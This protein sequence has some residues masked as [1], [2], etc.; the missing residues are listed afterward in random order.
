MAGTTDGV[1]RK[2]I[3]RAVLKEQKYLAGEALKRALMNLNPDAGRFGAET[4][5]FLAILDPGSEP[6]LSPAFLLEPTDAQH[7]EKHAR[8]KMGRMELLGAILKEDWLLVTGN[9]DAAAAQGTGKI[10]GPVLI[11]DDE[12]EGDAPS[13]GGS[14]EVDGGS[15]EVDADNG[16]PASRVA[17]HS[18]RNN[19]NGS[20]RGRRAPEPLGQ[21]VLRWTSS[22]MPVTGVVLTPEYTRKSLVLDL[23]AGATVGVMSVPQG[24][25]YA[26]LAGLPPERGMYAS[27]V[28]VIAYALCGGSR[29][30]SL[31][32]A[33]IDSLIVFGSLQGLGLLEK[34]A[35]A[36]AAASLMAFMVGVIQVLMGFLHVGSFV[37][38]LAKPVVAGFT[39]GS[40]VTIA[41]SQVKS[42][43]GL[44]SPKTY[45]YLIEQVYHTLPA[46]GETNG[47]ALGIGLS[48]IA[49]LVALKFIKGKPFLKR[50]APY[51]PDP[52][53]LVVFATLASYIVATRRP[54]RSPAAPV[55]GHIPS[56]FPAPSVGY[57]G[58]ASSGLKLIPDAFLL[59][60]IG[61]LETISIGVA[62]AEPKGHALAANR[63]FLVLG[64]CNLTSAI[65]GGFPVAALFSRSAVAATAGSVSQVAGLTSGVV[66]IL[67]SYAITPLLFYLPRSALAAIVIVAV[68]GLLRFDEAVR[69]FRARKTDF[70]MWAVAFAATA[71]A[72]VAYGIASSVAFSVFLV[73]L[74]A[75]RPRVTVLG[76][77]A[78]TNSYACVSLGLAKASPHFGVVP[79]RFEAPLVFFNAAY[80][81]ST[82]VDI[83][84]YF[85]A[86]HAIVI[87]FLAMPD[88][89]TTGV[90]AFEWVAADLTRR[91]IILAIAGPSPG[92]LGFLISSGVIQRHNIRVF[93]DVQAAVGSLTIIGKESGPIT[94]VL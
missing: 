25:A 66:V 20:R 63:E 86:M 35:E 30:L 80:L 43:F 73:V 44:R 58:L 88:M 59:A 8:K 22:L 93:V 15:A 61:Y 64:V 62:F 50:A 54:G 85:P 60:L 75:A 33:A 57:L 53:I 29:I 94:V 12:F 18:H 71:G 32:A 83:I 6:E 69:L 37:T 89:D 16:A 76:R 11:S 13:P 42:L 68:F 4:A 52:L 10:A 49:I 24:L 65:F 82:V 27:A 84:N 46:L 51:I 3:F 14:G 7:M 2:E 5:H 34:P 19:D 78:G 45:P 26:L 9:A 87:D 23:I 81:K 67:T 47:A 38:F 74:K 21:R 41:F 79:I 40:A 77:V 90:S 70:F 39:A 91:Q 72:G 28:P 17:L 92:V 56:G 1:L 55:V 48:S 36:A 31:G